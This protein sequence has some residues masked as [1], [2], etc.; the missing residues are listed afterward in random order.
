MRVLSIYFLFLAVAF[1]SLQSQVSA[2]TAKSEGVFCSSDAGKSPRL[3]S[4]END[5]GTTVAYGNKCVT[6]GLGCIPNDCPNGSNPPD[7]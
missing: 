6:G 4:C 3:I 7:K 5:N 2:A 1:F